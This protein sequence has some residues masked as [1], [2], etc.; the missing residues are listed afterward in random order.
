MKC[1]LLVSHLIDSYII[2][3]NDSNTL[4]MF[5]IA[6]RMQPNVP[7]WLVGNASEF[8]HVAVL[9]WWKQSDLELKWSELAMDYASMNGHVAVLEWWKQSNLELKWNRRLTW[10]ARTV[11]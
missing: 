8:G 3:S 6:L 7:P 4:Y 11:I 5:Q 2:D 10:H 1:T 9:E